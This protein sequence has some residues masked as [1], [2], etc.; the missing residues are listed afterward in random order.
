[1][2]TLTQKVEFLESRLEEAKG[3]LELKDSRVV[4]L[5][6]TINGG[7]STEDRN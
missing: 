2:C 6:A 3:V 4:E 1:M 5:E 7:K